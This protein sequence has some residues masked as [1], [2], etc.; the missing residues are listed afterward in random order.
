MA[1]KKRADNA[2]NTRSGCTASKA[3][4]A[5]LDESRESVKTTSEGT[6]R[7]GGRASQGTSKAAEET[8][9]MA[10]RMAAES[11]A[12]VRS[13]AETAI[14]QATRMVEDVTDSFARMFALPGMT[15]PQAFFDQTQ[16]GFDAVAQGNAVLMDGAQGAMKAWVEMTQES[17]NRG[18]SG[19]RAMMQ[20]RTLP[21]LVQAQ[22]AL[23]REEFEVFMDGTRRISE[24]SAQSMAEAAHRMTASSQAK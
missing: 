11:A 9:E 7:T 13:S 1:E 2:S 22:G 14:N 17:M 8:T 3:A 6:R 21:D 4:S 18:V 24:M 16:R 23:V 5:A 15:M 20:A 10:E 19:L 12:E